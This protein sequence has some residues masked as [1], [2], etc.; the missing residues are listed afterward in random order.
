MDTALSKGDFDLNSRGMPYLL[1]GL[2]QLMQRVSLALKVKKGSF[3][4]DENLGSELYLLNKQTDLL[5][6][7]TEMLIKEA[8]ANVPEIEISKI[9]VSF[10]EYEK[11]Q[12]SM[13]ISF[14]DEQGSLEVIV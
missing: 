4:L 7:R 2:A 10:N 12:I 6:K 11:L 14:G 9:K 1:G 3:S 13:I 8:I 5:E